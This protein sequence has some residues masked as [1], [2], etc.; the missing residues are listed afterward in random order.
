MG[1]EPSTRTVGEARE[2]G[3][4]IIE[5]TVEKADIASESFDVAMMDS[6]IEHVLDPLRVL[7]IVHRILRPRGVVVLKTP[8]FGGPAYRRH[9]KDWNGFRVG[10]H[11][12]LFTSQT[13]GRTLEQV[14][15]E[16]LTSPKRDRLL[17]DIFIL[18]ARKPAR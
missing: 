14:G 12:Y 17:D 11:T 8:R 10:Y 2:K 4:E 3:F 15:F 1:L 7:Q 16:V 13:L 9:G 18:W 6:V 5:G